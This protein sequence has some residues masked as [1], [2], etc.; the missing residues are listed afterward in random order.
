[1]REFQ[2]SALVHHQSLAQRTTLGIGGEARYSYTAPSAQDLWLAIR[3]A[4][5]QQL[6]WMILGGGSNLV[7]PDSGFPG[8]VISLGMTDVTVA[9][10]DGQVGWQVAAGVN[11]DAL[12][13]QTVAHNHAGIECLS[14][15]PG[16]VG[17]API[18][19]IGA[20]G[21]ELA[22]VLTRVQ[23]LDVETGGVEWMA[24]SECGLAYRTS[25][26]KHGRDV[27]R[28][29]VLA[30]DLLLNPDGSPTLRYPDLLRR[31][32]ADASLAQT[33]DAVLAVRRE[34]SMVA[35]RADPNA[36]SCGSFFTNP[37]ISDGDYA[38]FLK[39]DVGEH[40]HYPA[41]I[42][43][44]KLSAAWLIQHA[45]FTRGYVKGGV[46]LSEKHCLAIINRGAGTAAEIMA[47]KDELQAGVYKRFGIALEPEPVIVKPMASG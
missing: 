47:L 18:Q 6:P 25:R 40:P 36:W 24:A 33:R 5:A 45:G 7:F 16:Q 2:E 22:Q 21:Q 26:F 37:I 19:N 32:A 34:K 17:A 8:L 35:D 38:A 15:I 12:V 10:R 14:G 13:A 44:V 28:F 3:W 42:G 27:G 46:G 23:V 11:W 30:V 29:V 31:L 20:Y 41:G 43:Q 9:P 39:R 4:K 1:M